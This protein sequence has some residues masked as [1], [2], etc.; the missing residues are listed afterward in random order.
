MNTQLS[1]K[2]VLSD[3]HGVFIPQIYCEGADE[4]WAQSVGVDYRD[5]E[6]C[7]AGPDHEWYWEAW[8]NILNEAHTVVD[9]VTWRLVQDGDL[10][11]V[12]DGY[13]WPEM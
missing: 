4:E 10:F 13:E 12:P 7:Q 9:G 5:V 2:L 6:T 11:E 8:N 1:P 3:S